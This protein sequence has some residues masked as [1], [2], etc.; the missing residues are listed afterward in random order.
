VSELHGDPDALSMACPRSAAEELAARLPPGPVVELCCGVGGIT[1]AL[2]R[3]GPVVAVDR[4]LR[5]L[6]A[7]RRNLAR[8]GL[9]DRVQLLCCDLRRPAL[10]ARKGYAFAACVLD[11]D[12]APAGR[13]PRVWTRRLEEM[14]PP[15]PALVA[16][17]LELAPRVVV[18]LPREADPVPLAS[19]GRV[20]AL[21]A[22][23]ARR[24]HFLLLQGD[25]APGG[26]P[27]GTW[28]PGGGDSSRE[29]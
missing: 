6:A 28:Y 9:A 8:Y 18:R 29:G 24:F 22:R 17:G 10:R 27:P 16:L 15:V 20:Q 7:N 12:W 25:E 14:Q 11:P 3:R 26:S 13:P 5:R 2:A 21:P 1:R 19:L 4:D 23:R